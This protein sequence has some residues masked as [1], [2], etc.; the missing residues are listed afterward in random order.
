MGAVCCR[1]DTTDGNRCLYIMTLG[2]LA[3]Y[4]RYG[5]GEK[6]F[7]NH[8]VFFLLIKLQLSSFATTSVVFR[9]FCP[10]ISNH[11]LFYSGTLML[12]H[13]LDIC[14]KDGNFDSIYL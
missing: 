5:A 2:V 10:G 11:Y 4:R 8:L 7:M 3:A 12:K 13:V 9:E 6:R 1:V 14:E